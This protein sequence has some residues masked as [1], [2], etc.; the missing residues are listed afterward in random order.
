MRTRML[1][2]LALLGPALALAQGVKRGEP[3]T[4]TLPLLLKNGGTLSLGSSPYIAEGPNTLTHVWFDGTSIR[5]TKTACNWTQV[6]TVPQVAATSST[7]AGAGPFSSGNVY[8]CDPNG[9]GNDPLDVTADFC[10]CALYSST[11]GGDAAHWIYFNAANSGAYGGVELRADG[12]VYMNSGAAVLSFSTG[13]VAASG[14]TL[15]CWGRTGTVGTGRSGIANGTPTATVG[16]AANTSVAAI[17]GGTSAAG[18]NPFNG[19][20]YEFWFASPCSAS[21]ASTSAKVVQTLA[22][23]PP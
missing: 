3:F 22:V 1:L 15:S 23:L 14:M 16:T 4:V 8:K 6:G 7:P 17:L 18:A 19:V 13:P 12:T 5:D 20:L 10:A 2:P 11:G 9:N 21:D